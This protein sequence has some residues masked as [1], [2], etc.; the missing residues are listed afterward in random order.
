MGF[1]YSITA[2]GCVV[3]QAAINGMG[4]TAVA[5]VAAASKVMGFLQCPFEALG[6]TMATYGAQNVGAKRYERLDRGVIAASVMGFVYSALAFAVAVLL[7]DHLVGLFVSRE[8]SV[9]MI[10]MAHVYMKTTAITYPLLTLV[11]VVRLTIQGMGFSVIAVIAGVLEMVARALAGVWL[12]PVWGIVGAG[13]GSPLAWVFA[14]LF[15]IP[16]YFRCKCL[17]MGKVH[18]MNAQQS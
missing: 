17:V 1:Q 2:V 5:A 15:L 12:V 16:T 18:H 14:D 8:G 4:A 13:L 10:G 9:E 3:L 7:G 6:A 11:N